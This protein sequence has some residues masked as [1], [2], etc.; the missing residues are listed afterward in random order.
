M[1]LFFQNVIHLGLLISRTI[2]WL[3]IPNWTLKFFSFTL[4]SLTDIR[5]WI[6]GWT[7]KTD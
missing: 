2:V 4:R 6:L 1:L 5:G 7:W 3:E